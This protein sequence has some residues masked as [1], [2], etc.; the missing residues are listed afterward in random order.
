MSRHPSRARLLL[1]VPA[2]AL[3]AACQ[4][5]PPSIPEV[6]L[7]AHDFAFT[8]PDTIAGGLVTFHLMNDG[9]ENHHAQFI[10]LNDGVTRA[11]FD[12]VLGAVMAALPTEGEAAFG[13]LF[14]IITLAG[15]PSVVAPGGE[16]AVTLDLG[17]GDYAL[18]CFIASP[19]GVLHVAKGMR[20]WLT[21]TAPPAASPPPPVADGRVDMAD[22]AFT[23]MPEVHAGPV[24]L[25]VTN[26][27]QE[28]HEMVVVR[29]E[30]I[31]LDQLL[32][33]LTQP[34][35]SAQ[36]P[37]G[38]PPFTFVG[39]M[40][41]IMPGAHGWVG[42]DLTPGEYALICFIPSPAHEGKPHVALGMARAFTVS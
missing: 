38:P 27:G 7:E 20:H 6:Q 41:G 26:S 12:S 39:G 16:E 4:S 15:G 40:Q 14:E 34:P 9:Q 29:L 33:M 19:D 35:D 23:T 37:A 17:A 11:Q 30:G 32:S 18:A 42:L 2:A 3:L 24:T 1:A 5:T 13:R 28:P 21:V 22:F 36:A 10:R 25:E 8:L 31:G